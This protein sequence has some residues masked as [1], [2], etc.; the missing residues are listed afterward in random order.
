[1]RRIDR[2][3]VKGSIEA[4]DL[5][6]CD[7]DLENLKDKITVGDIDKYKTDKLTRNEKKTL[8]FRNKMKRDEFK[9]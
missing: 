5:Y 9:K 6:T 7:A 8:N 2:V 1:M 3:T 4:I